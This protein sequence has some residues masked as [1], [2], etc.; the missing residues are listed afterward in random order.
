MFTD[1]VEGLTKHQQSRQH[2]RQALPRSK[3]HAPCQRSGMLGWP[4]T[5]LPEGMSSHRLSMHAC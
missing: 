4:H 2:S 1:R 3:R 5:D